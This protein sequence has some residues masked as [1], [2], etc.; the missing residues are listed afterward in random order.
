[1]A[2]REFLLW[3]QESAYKT[4]VGSPV[5]GTN[6]LY[7][8]LPDSNS[9]TG[10][11]KPMVVKV[12][13]G[14]GQ[15]T[16]AY[17]V[18]DKTECKFSLKTPFYASQAALLLPWAG[19]Q[20]NTGQT[21]P[22]VTTEPAGDL[23]SASLYHGIQRS[24]GSI[25]RRVYLGAKV[26]SWGFD[27]SGEGQQG[28]LNFEIQASTPQGNQ[29]DSS[30][31]PSAGTFAVPTDAQLPT[32]PYLFIHAAGNL[33]FGSSR[34][35]FEDFAFK[36]TNIMD[37]RWFENRYANIIR[38]FGR[39]TT[40]S[41]SLYYKPTPDD[42]TAMEGLT[43]E[44]VSLELNNSVHTCTVTMNAANIYSDTDDDLGIDKAYMQKVTVQ[45]QYD[46]AAPG[47]FTLAFT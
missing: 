26:N 30:T 23:I 11:P 39:D 42:R 13:R 14:G 2:A 8:R 33:T 4:P 19:Q 28:I 31:D 32:D 10:R 47:D 5:L 7:I 6:S 43:T 40:L 38:F 36:S 37:A 27:F 44:T 18:S 46:S 35:Q 20:I 15:A 34:T 24:D 16:Q 17:T 45:N 9:F 22:W 41:S 3:V 25:K 21:T 1:M 12:K 29:F